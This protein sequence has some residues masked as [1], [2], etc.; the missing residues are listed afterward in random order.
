[1]QQGRPP[2][3]LPYPWRSVPTGLGATKSWRSPRGTIRFA[4][5]F[6]SSLGDGI[7]MVEA[8]DEAHAADITQAQFPDALLKVVPAS[9]IEGKDR[10]R[11]LFRWLDTL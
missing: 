2:S 11:L 8:L 10:H 9:A 4:V 5:F 7:E 1:M 6:S 3:L